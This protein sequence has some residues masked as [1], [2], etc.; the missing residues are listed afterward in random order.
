L[1]RRNHLEPQKSPGRSGRCRPSRA[2]P[3]PRSS[4]TRR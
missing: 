4:R 2:V 3:L 1:R